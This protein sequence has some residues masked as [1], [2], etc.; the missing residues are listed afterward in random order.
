MR[1]ALG[2]RPRDLV[3]LV[4]REGIAQAALGTGLGLLG[5]A[6]GG[7]LLASLLYATSSLDLT[8]FATVAGV[9]GLVSLLACYVPAR[10]A[11]RLDPVAALRDE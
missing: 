3:G 11:G 8:T 1:A 6:A 9:L 7:R 5:A 10:R 2:A 4:L